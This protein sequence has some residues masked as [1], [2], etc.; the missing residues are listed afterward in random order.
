MIGHGILIL[1]MALVAG[2]GL[3]MD[4]LGGF[5]FI[6]GT[7]THFNVLGTSDGWA[8]AHR[9]TPMNSLMMAD[10]ILVPSH[11]GSVPEGKRRTKLKFKRNNLKFLVYVLLHSE[12]FSQSCGLLFTF[13]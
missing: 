1:F 3:W 7:V 8:K 11:L 4:L 6:P 12:L 9:G 2:M 13:L 5:E 10:V